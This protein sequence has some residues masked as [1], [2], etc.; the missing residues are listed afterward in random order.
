MKIALFLPNWLGD[1]VMATPAL[2][3]VRKHFHAA[4]ITGIMRPNLSGL[5]AGTA[6]IDE[7]WFCDPRAKDRDLGR[8]ALVRRMRRQRFDLAI[9][10]PN[11]LHSA[12]LAWAG[13]ARRRIGY[14]RDGRR[15]LLTEAVTAPRV[16]GQL[17]LG[18]MVDYYLGLAKAA[19]CPQESPRLELHVTAAE[20]RLAEETFQRLGLRSD[21]HLVAFNAGSAYGDSKSWP[22]T[23]FGELARRI[24]DLLDHDVLVICGPAEKS[25]ARAIVRSSQ[26]Q[27]VF[28]L[29]DQPIGLGLS[30]GAIARCRFMVST[31]SGPRHVAAALGKPVITLFGPT[32]PIITANPTVQAVDLQ[33]KLDCVPCRR[34]TCPLEHHRCMR[35]L[36]VDAVFAEAASLA[37]KE[38][39]PAAA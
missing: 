24:I 9:L 34:R 19:G 14:A 10:F 15:L 16:E 38:R 22:V 27:R 13:G 32:P 28:S 7:A 3:A 21:R 29:A 25:L 23:A 36:P 4:R 17:D 37:Q 33:V 35:E 5:L 18:P 8:W 30:K 26:R 20:E 11:S 31:D 6:W 39:A 1:L 12:L 2:R